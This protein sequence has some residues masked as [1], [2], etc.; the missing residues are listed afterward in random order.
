MAFLFWLT[1]VSWL[2][3]HNSFQ[4]SRTTATIG[5]MLA[6]ACKIRYVMLDFMGIRAAPLLLRAFCE[7]WIFLLVSVILM[8]LLPGSR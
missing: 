2:L 4:L 5:I 3:G 6:A 8:L 7:A 1:G